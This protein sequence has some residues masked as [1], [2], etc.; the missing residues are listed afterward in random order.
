MTKPN[1]CFAKT[2]L[3]LFS[4]S[5][6][7]ASGTRGQASAMPATPP[8]MVFEALPSRQLLARGEAV[9]LVLYL[10]NRSEGQVFGSRLAGDEF[11]D[12]SVIGPDGKEV[13]WRGKGRIE[14]KG[15]SP[16]DFA[17]LERYQ[18]ISA[19]RIISLKDGAGFVFEKP[20]QYSVTAEYSLEPPEYFAPF[21]GETKIP[22][23][24]FRSTKAAFCI[25]ACIL[26][27]LRV[28]GNASQSAL[29]AV[30]GFY[31][32]IIRYRPLGIP[33]EPAR[34][35]LWPLLSKRL[36]QELDGF[37]AC[38]DDYYQRYGD[39]LPANQ[40]KPATPWLEEGLFS[41]PNEAAG[42]MKFSILS[43]S[44][45]GNNRVDVHLRFTQKRPDCCG[46]PASYDH[47]EG[48]VTAILENNRWVIDDFVGM[49][50]NDDLLRLSSGYPECEGGQW[51]GKTP[52]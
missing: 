31:T 17:V 5:V 35:V 27:P 34:K 16:A 2:L 26:E 45:I 40:Y 49:Y 15:Y 41:G 20:G 44:A 6:V 7:L 24:T 52:Y 48:V 32:Y 43:S 39:I 42:P 14:S 18:E 12:F 29:D 37:Q 47:W 36:V 33:Q 51:V 10:R 11:V 19:K 3:F 8:V 21:A 4:F 22:T 28:H 23:G 13:P 1:R 38:E 30:R 25:E 46:N 9:V 50:E